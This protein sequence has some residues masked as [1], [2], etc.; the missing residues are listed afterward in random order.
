[1]AATHDGTHLSADEALERLIKGNQRFLRGESRNSTFHQETLAQL[2]KAQT[3]YATVLGCS[4]SRVAPE[5]IFDTGFG[6]LFVIRVAGNVLSPEIAGTLQYAGSYLKTP[7]F[8]VLGHEGC[9]AIRAALA[10]KHEGTQF[11]SRLQ[12]LLTSI[13]PGLPEF[14]PELSLSEQASRA[15]ESN[16]RWTVQQILDSPEGQASI[17]KGRTKVVGAIY[18][19]E[20]GRVKFLSPNK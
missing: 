18:E 3:P 16:V 13:I 6:E 11:G 1:M 7:L 9:G 5:G 4:D 20:T 19:I 15:T 14:N 12:V 8:V 17:E 10:T 2:A